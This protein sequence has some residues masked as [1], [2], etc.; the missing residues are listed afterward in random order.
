MVRR[1]NG[2]RRHQ[3]VGAQQVPPFEIIDESHKVGQEVSGDLS[4]LLHV[5]LEMVLFFS[6]IRCIRI[7]NEIDVHCPPF[8][9]QVTARPIFG[10][11]DLQL[12]AV[13]GYDR[14][15]KIGIWILCYHERED[16]LAIPDGSDLTGKQWRPSLTLSEAVTRNTTER[17]R[18]THEIFPE[19][20]I[21]KATREFAPARRWSSCVVAVERKLIESVVTRV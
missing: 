11:L 7:S 1:T 12:S 10:P 19:D 13:A 5:Y 14:F 16:S 15:C 21:R 8:H 4:E 9:P 20:V 6:W 17:A 3:E 2:R 18:S